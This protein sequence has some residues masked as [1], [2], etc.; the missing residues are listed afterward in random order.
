MNI[1]WCIQYYTSVKLYYIIEESTWNYILTERE[2][3]SWKHRDSNN[4][5]ILQQKK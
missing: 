3:F 2:A 5:I 1:H 4:F